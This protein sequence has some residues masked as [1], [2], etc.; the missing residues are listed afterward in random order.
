M[1]ITKNKQK[2]HNGFSWSKYLKKMIA[3]CPSPFTCK[4]TVEKGHE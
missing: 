1:F 4:T 2:Q 3:L